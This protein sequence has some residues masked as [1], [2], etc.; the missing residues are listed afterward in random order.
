M[1]VRKRLF[2][3]GILSLIIINTLRFPLYG[4]PVYPDI[5]GEAAILMDGNTGEVLYSKNENKRLYPASITK[6]ATALI[7]IENRKPT[8]IITM[9]KESVFSIEPGSSHIGLDVGEQINLDQGL[10]AL[11]LASA[12]E[13]ANGI[14]E[15][16]DGSIED[17][18]RHMTRRAKELGAKNT[19]FTNPHGLHDPNHYTTA[20][21][22][23]LITREAV[24][25]PYFQHIMEE[26]TYQI[27]PT[28]KTS[29]IRYL[30]QQHRLMNEL[31]DSRMYRN[32]VIAGKTGFTNEAGNTLVTV[33][34]R[35]DVE[36]ICVVLKSN[37]A[38]LYSDTNILLDYGFDNFKCISLHQKSNIIGVVPMYTIKSGQL[39][40]MADCNIAVEDDITI[41]TS[42]DLKQRKIDTII[43]LPPRIEKNASLGDVV[44]TIVYKYEGEPLAT[45]NLVIEELNYI[46]AL[47]PA[48]FPQKPKYIIPA[49]NIPQ[50]LDLAL[51]CFT[52]IIVI[53]GIFRLNIMHCRRIKREA[54]RKKTL[55]F[56]KT[57]K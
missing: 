7:A 3:Y 18:A 56:S 15:L 52:A 54:T 4:N 13:A 10:H 30:S 33:A 37:G 6:L 1:F 24:R 39:I 43:S 19:N 41:L 49:T 48:T 47:E 26:T 2:L 36:L 22:M 55:R 20:Y 44:G 50:G 8:D 16:C 40:H 45:N 21:D 25:Q 31:R 35:G 51:L 34:K 23:A 12:N 53:G 11:L 28:N 42:S 57:I 14:A 17:F 32:D 29:E 9:S 5:F 38:N 27:P 46:P